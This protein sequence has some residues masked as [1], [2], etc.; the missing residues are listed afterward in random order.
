V[1]AAAVLGFGLQTGALPAL[2][3]TVMSPDYDGDA[4]AAARAAAEGSSPAKI[5]LFTIGNMCAHR[6]TRCVQ[7]CMEARPYRLYLVAAGNCLHLAFFVRGQVVELFSLFLN[8][9]ERQLCS[10]LNKAVCAQPQPQPLCNITLHNHGTGA[11]C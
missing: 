3:R 10:M 5:A 7:C 8:N 6:E 2:L 11:H 9:F 1:S 4:V